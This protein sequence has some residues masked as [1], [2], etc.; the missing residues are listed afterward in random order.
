MRICSALKAR[1]VDK[2]SNDTDKCVYIGDRSAKQEHIF[3]LLFKKMTLRK[4]T[5]YRI[6]LLILSSR[7]RLFDVFK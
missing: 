1:I 2:P 6:N 7:L 4:I 3:S 5:Y